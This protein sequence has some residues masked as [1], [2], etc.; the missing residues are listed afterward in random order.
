M[1]VSLEDWFDKQHDR[2]LEQWKVLLS[3]PSISTAP[4]HR[5]DCLDCAGW[6]AN[7]LAGLGFRSRLLET[8]RLPVVYGEMEGPPGAP[9]VLLYGHY[10]VQPVDPM[11]AWSHPPFSPVVEDGRMLARGAADNKGQHFYILKA[12]E[13]LRAQ[14]D[15]RVGVK[16]LIEGE[17]ECGS[18]GMTGSLAGWKDLLGADVLV[19]TDTNTV[20]SGAPTLVMG[21]RGLVHLTVELTGPRHD[22]HSGNHGG[23]APNPA[24]AM[25]RLLATLRAADGSVA[26][27]GFYDGLEE[28]T[29][30]EKALSKLSPFD[31]SS[32]AE[33]TGVPPVAGE[34]GYPPDE[35]IGFRPSL[36]VNGILSGYAGAGVKTIIPA[37]ATAKLTARLVPGQD[38][39]RCLDALI[40]HL[41]THAP[42]GLRIQITEQ[43]IGGKGFRL[44]P[45]SAI[46]STAREV[47]DGLGRENSVMLWDGASI[48]VISA[49]SALLGIEP[50]LAGFGS[51]ADRAH[52][53]NESFPIDR[54]RTGYLYIGRLLQSLGE[55][56]IP[57]G[58]KATPTPA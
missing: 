26:A 48:P 10:D 25:A 32:Y 2:I 5:Q 31:E 53:P 34:T 14:D 6:L 54:F 20:S 22:L 57:G 36:D 3:F 55:R 51:D 42:E 18:V 35:R 1:P 16:V 52:A 45:G 4:E 21:L 43:G 11:E 19:V 24:E 40:A 15:L 50:V 27:E 30:K 7:H 41:H 17:E 38:P 12:I 37:L 47:L 39:A 49:L 33:R 9:V 23:V 58:S 46:A 44:D 56:G 29:E 28:P 13:A 8:S